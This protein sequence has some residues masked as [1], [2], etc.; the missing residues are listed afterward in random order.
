MESKNGT[1]CISEFKTCLTCGKSFSKKKRE[2]NSTWQKKKFCC[3]ECVRYGPP[4]EEKRRK[5]GDANRGIRNGNYGKLAWN[6]GIKCPQ[7][8]NKYQTGINNRNW[9]GGKPSCPICGKKLSTRKSKYCRDHYNKQGC[10]NPNWNNGSSFSPYCEKFNHRL[11]ETIRNRDGRTCQL[12]RISEI[13][14]GRKLDVHHIHHDR[15]NCYPD[16]ISL[17][18]TCNSKV[19]GNKKYY[20]KLFMNKLNDREL[21]FW[22]VRYLKEKK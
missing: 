15:E 8:G 19:N 11:K 10:N 16:L 6:S 1:V 18:W 17:C 4:S 13:N 22:T 9:K 3:R 5:I 12:C 14:N 7:T 2:S 21:L 20:E